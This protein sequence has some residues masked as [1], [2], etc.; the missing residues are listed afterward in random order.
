MHYIRFLKT[1]KVTA[2]AGKI[3][4]NASIT[5]TT[6]LGETFY[7]GD[8][9]LAGTLRSPDRDGDIYLRRSL[10]WTAGM[11]SLP[12]TFDLTRSEIE[13]PAQLHVSLKTPRGELADD[14]ETFSGQ[15]DHDTPAFISVWSESLNA[16]RGNFEAARRVERRFT[17]LSGRSLRIWED[18]GDS[19]AR[20]LWDGSVALT[21]F[22]DRVIALQ[23][24]A[25]VPPLE[26][27]LVSATF[28]RLNVI[29]LGC[30]CGIVGIGL[31]QSIPD[32]DVLLTDLPE[33]QELVEKNISTANL[34]ISSRVEFAPLDWESKLP[35][36]VASRNFDIIV[37]AECIYNSDSI[38]P[39]VQTIKALVTRS[40]KAI[41]LIATKFRHDS[42]LEFFTL[43][44]KAG[45]FSSTKSTLPLPGP[46]GYGYADFSKEV[47][48]HILVGPNYRA[49]FSPAFESDKALELS[50]GSE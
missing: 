29:E 42:E 1:P 11:R 7:D 20:H 18:T 24:S 12:I 26:H 14:F 13:W 3:T 37:A 45:L 19:I 22:I 48:L 34:A 8:V 9:D 5:L 49:S 50:S 25:A 31:A 17:P 10:K 39:L 44:A 38:P 32:S 27:A 23:A 16:T 35:K 6:D 15:P 46:P 41:V 36:A 30:G 40:P 4:L 2:A 47:A 43:A 21:A 28:K 33:V